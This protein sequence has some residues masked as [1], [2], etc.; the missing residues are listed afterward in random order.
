MTVKAARL[1]VYTDYLYARRGSEVR[2]DRA[3]AL[4]VARLAPAF[5]RVIAVGRLD[6]SGAAAKY[7]IGDGV[8]FVELP[9]YPALT[10]I[11]AVLSAMARSL[12]AYWSVLGE[13]DVV[14]LLGP[15]PLALAFA[16]AALL[17]GKRVIL[18]VRQ[19]LVPY[20]RARRPGR[21]GLIFAAWLLEEAFRGLARVCPVV[22]V[23]P[24][25][26][27]NYRHSKALLD[28]AISLVPAAEVLDP[29]EALARDFTGTL[30]LLS[31]G[32]LDAEKNPL[33]LAD[34]L[35]A[36]LAEENRWRLIVCGEGPMEEELSARLE[37]LG[38][39]D[40]AELRG[41]VPNDQGLRE[42]YRQSH[43]FLHVSWTEGRPQVLLE[44]LAAG[45]PIV[46]TDV[47]G[48]GE[49]LGAAALHISP[50]DPIPAVAALKAIANDGE[51]REALI[52]A[53]HAYALDHTAELESQKV[54]RFLTG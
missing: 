51:L 3:F 27:G 10:N 39:A 42:A 38:V 43:A 1:C 54:A 14:W 19:D 35:A 13:V 46:A 49:A 8:E 23:G 5:E 16:L 2:A 45:L 47:G 26:A 52:L 34:I 4:F 22:V 36:L 33:I 7:A 17:R 24:A 9:F 31:V 28:V 18:G 44:A 6:R 15:H 29:A 12:R 48:V 21:R 25:L 30:R 41:Y 11:F 40:H 32:R 50:G 37:E 53:G 20:V